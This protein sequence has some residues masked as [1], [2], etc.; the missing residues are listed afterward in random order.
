MRTI[1]FSLLFLGA[2]MAAEGE[3]KATGLRCDFRENPLG[4][5]DA[6]PR[7]SWTV[8]SEARGATQSA[9][10]IMAATRSG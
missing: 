2:A 9:F 10:R 4:I 7:L 6:R 1:A 5:E 3:M 8:F